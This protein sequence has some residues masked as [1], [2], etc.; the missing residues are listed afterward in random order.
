MLWQQSDSMNER[1]KFVAAVQSGVESMAVTCRR[2]GVSRRTGYK[3]LRRYEEDG[4]EGL[5][6]RSSA[7]GDERSKLA[8]P[9]G[10]RA[11][12]AFAWRSASG[13]AGQQGWQGCHATGPASA[14]DANP[15]SASA[16]TTTISRPPRG[17]PALEGA[18]LERDTL[19][20]GKTALS[21]TVRVAVPHPLVAVAATSLLRG[22][23]DRRVVSEFLHDGGHKGGGEVAEDGV[24]T[25]E[26][27]WAERDAGQ[28]PYVLRTDAEVRDSSGLR[29]AT[30]IRAGAYELRT[31]DGR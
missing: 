21:T 19:V 20:P 3:L 27:T 4:P 22:R 31:P 5:Q 26:G 25:L 13:D 15:A 2:F 23:V 8:A 28:G 11:R 18:T 17:A 1:M 29:H 9:K 24:F 7:P 12:S 14:E 30:A 16:N 6:D 10:R